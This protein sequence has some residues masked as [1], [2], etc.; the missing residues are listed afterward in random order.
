MKKYRVYGT[1]EVVVC[2]EV[3][4]INEEQ[5]YEKAFDQLSSLTEYCG[6]GGGD[7]LIGVD[8]IDESVD[9]CGNEIEYDDI[10]L[11]EDNPD[12]M[13]CPDCNEELEEYEG[14]NGKKFWKC[15]CCGTCYDEDCNEVDPSDYYDE[16]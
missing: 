2:K 16:E 13:E 4:A 5:A 15:E 9:T 8:G 12:Y 10:E 11:L 6:N 7:K 1:V 14:D 3:W